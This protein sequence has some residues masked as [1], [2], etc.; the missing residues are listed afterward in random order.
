MGFESDAVIDS[1]I[2]ARP[3]DLGLVVLIGLPGAGKTTYYRNALQCLGYERIN[4]HALG[5]LG[6]CVRAA[7]QF[8]SDGKI[9]C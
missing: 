2:S 6:D 7:D 1:V 8:L 3:E 5:S 9:V 4:K